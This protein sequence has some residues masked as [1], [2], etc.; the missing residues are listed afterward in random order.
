MAGS[1]ASE[2]QHHMTLPP[3]LDYDQGVTTVVKSAMIALYHLRVR[4]YP[5]QRSQQK[6]QMK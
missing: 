2:L 4:T 3:E 1:L 6:K 5:Q